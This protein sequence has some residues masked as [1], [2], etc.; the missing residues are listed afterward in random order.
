V[1]IVS[2]DRHVTYLGIRRGWCN[3]GCGFTG[4][5]TRWTHDAGTQINAHLTEVNKPA[6]PPL[7]DRRGDM[8]RRYVG[9]GYVPPTG[10][11]AA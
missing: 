9:G 10:G 4:K 3:P 11:T 7:V 8:R 5:A 1:G 2:T 6:L